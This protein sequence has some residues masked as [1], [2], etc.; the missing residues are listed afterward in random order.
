[1][2]HALLLLIAWTPLERPQL[3]YEPPPR[4]GLVWVAPH[5][6][7]NGTEVDGHWRTAPD[8]KAW[9]NW[10]TRGNVNPITGRIGTRNF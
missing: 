4:P 8:G 9:N 3:P 2:L 1:M 7:A 10:S 5:T 6:R